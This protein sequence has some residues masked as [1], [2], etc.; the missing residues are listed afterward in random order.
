MKKGSSQTTCE[1][2]RLKISVTMS[3]LTGGLEAVNVMKGMIAHSCMAASIRSELT[4]P[5]GALEPRPNID[6]AV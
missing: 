3:S 6:M 5:E 4:A 1:T 2:R